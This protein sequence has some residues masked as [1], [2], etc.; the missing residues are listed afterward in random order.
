[1]CNNKRTIMPKEFSI[2]WL[3]G[4]VLVWAGACL[5]AANDPSLIGWWLLDES[6]GTVATDSSG[7]GNNATLNGSAVFTAG[8]YGRGVYCD[9]TE[10][11]VAIPNILPATC[12]LAFWF[13]PDWDGTDASDYRLFDAGAGDKYFF[14]AKGSTNTAMPATY[15]GFFFEDSTDFDFQNVRITAA[16]AI[17]A[18]TWC[19][20]T[21]TWQFGGGAGIL[22]V[23]GTEVSRASNLGAFAT[24]STSPRFGY[25]TGGGGV[26]GTRG[27]A[28]VF[29]DIK[30]FNRV[31]TAAEIPGLMQGTTLEMA[32]SPTPADKATDVSR[33]T[34]LSWSRGIYA[35]AH[36]VYLGTGF[37]DVNT[38]SRTTPKGLLAGTAQDAN[39]FD[40]AGV[41]QYGQTYYWRIDEVNA[42]PSSTLFAGSVWSFTVEPLAYTLTNIAATASSRNSASE[43][44]ENTTNGSGLTGDLHGS[45]YTTMWL[46]L[47]SKN[48]GSLPAW[49]RYD[50]DKAYKLHEMWVW[51]HNTLFESIIGLGA[52]NATIEYSSDGTTWTKLGD[53]EFAQASGA[54]AYAHDTAVSF[55]GA[56]AKSV[57]ITINSNW[58]GTAQTGLSEVRFFYIPVSAREPQPVTGA[59][60]VSPST[61]LRWRSGRE[62]VSH[63]VYMGTDPNALTPA[64]SSPINSFSPASLSLGMKYY[65]RVDEVN[66]AEAIRTWAGDVWSF[67]TPD[68]IAIDDME[69]Y[70]DAAGT[71]IFN[72]WAD[73]YNTSTNG[74]QV[75]NDNP[76][77]AEK[78]IVHGGSQSMPLKYDNSSTGS[79]ETTRT[80]EPAQ[81]WTFG[82]AKTLVL[83]FYGNISNTTGQFYVKINGTKVQ[84]GD[85]SA[86]ALPWWTQ[87]NIDLASVAG[88]VKAVKTLTV[89]ISGSGK[90][91]LYI[92]D[93][94]LYRV[95]PTAGTEQLYI[96]AEAATPTVPAPWVITNEVLASGGKY[97]TT[98]T[99]TTSS[100]SAPPTAGVATYNFTVKGGAYRL[101]LRLGPLVGYDNDSLWVRIKDA[102]IDPTGNAAN[103]GWIRCN[104]LAGQTGAAG[105]HWGQV[106][107][108]EHAS[109]QVTFTL[110][111]GSHALEIGYREPAV[112][113]DAILITNN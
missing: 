85:A 102:T 35:A 22:Y 107:D 2:Q 1:M 72:T 84:Y 73:G 48:G 95:A 97:I 111:A 28:A 15:F 66:A 69:S 53:F 101:W 4:A 38:A 90:G 55:G 77:Y 9:G 40:P 78:T 81:D 50:F 67:T 105:W 30:V 80:F 49:I 44:P 109:V 60:G 82:G 18:K 45:D 71:A 110:P 51:N 10:G 64:G 112:L 103:P 94:R 87:W 108:D 32:S 17:T 16:G 113:L 75:G 11:Y 91:T 98:P 43:T 6:G 61:S 63:S 24:L 106:W 21:V 5:G 89:G 88:G 92:D 74:S 57:R 41:F 54:D 70:N 42:P 23:N 93:I 26:A 99:T 37:T 96:E 79:S 68:Y 47:S 33:D 14:I 52:R 65:W 39:T 29:D 19:H 13:K 59:T 12:T 7:K 3:L 8:R 25:A 46:S 27:A 56:A 62:A 36:D 76:P 100:T 86:L 104:G 34:A 20:V 83:Y 31:L 58:S